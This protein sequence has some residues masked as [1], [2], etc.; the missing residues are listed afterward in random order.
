M[1]W[2]LLDAVEALLGAMVRAMCLALLV[3]LVVV[4]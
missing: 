1:V 3:V 4:T 2:R